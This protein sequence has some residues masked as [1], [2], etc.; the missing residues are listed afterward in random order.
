M[1]ENWPNV[2]MQ[3]QKKKETHT[4]LAMW[5]MKQL[6][7]EARYHDKDIYVQNF[8]VPFPLVMYCNRLILVLMACVRLLRESI[9]GIK[10]I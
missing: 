2:E 4:L 1:K 7:I 6:N 3:K 9:N 10:M 5:L 8:K